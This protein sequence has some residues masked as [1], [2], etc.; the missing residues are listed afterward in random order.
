M[1]HLAIACSVIALS[2]CSTIT[3]GTTEAFSVETDPP[4]AKV[5]TSLGTMC[6]PTP[7]VIPK[8]SREADF[9]V[10]IE[11]EGYETTTHNV[12]HQTAGAGAA[13][14]AG[15]VILGGGLGAIVDANTGATQELVPNPL[16][17]KLKAIDSDDAEEAD[18]RFQTAKDQC[19]ELGF[20]E[21]SEKFADC[22]MQMSVS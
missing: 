4:G 8:V 7:C 12:T 11:L 17:V 19:S 13:G 22:V 5:T 21:G 9:T 20:E 16:V 2:A 10:T 15:N 3:R 18:D 6:E 14:M 1:K